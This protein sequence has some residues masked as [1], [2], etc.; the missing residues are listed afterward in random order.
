[1]TLLWYSPLVDG[2]DGGDESYRREGIV[3]GLPK[4]AREGL[5]LMI[6]ANE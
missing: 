1:V 3:T 5:M 4:M 6:D 2:D